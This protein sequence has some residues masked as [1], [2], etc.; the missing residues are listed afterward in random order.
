MIDADAPI[1]TFDQI[2]STLLEAR[3]RAEAG[4]VSAA[5]LVA[6]EQ[7][8]GRGRRGRVWVSRRGNL[9]ATYLGPTARAPADIALLGFAAALALSDVIDAIA[10]SS[11]TTLKW[12]ND[13][14]LDGAKAAGILLES[15]AGW[16]SLSFGVNLAHAPKSVDQAT[17]SLAEAL[18][19]GD[20]PE[21]FFEQARLALTGWCARLETEGFAPLRAAWMARAHRLGGK[22]RVVLG[23]E[24]LEGVLAGLS[25]RG[26]LE[27]DTPNGRRLIAAGDVH[28]TVV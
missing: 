27:L 5:W 4:G 26:E 8:D 3:R 11:R 6:R 7:S 2:D 15:G 23:S 14:M 21:P 20:T 16:F 19:A 12:P 22:V 13:V 18:G 28:F 25:E 9:Y 24:E 10:G 1:E 17:T